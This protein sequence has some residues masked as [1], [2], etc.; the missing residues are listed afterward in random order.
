MNLFKYLHYYIYT[1]KMKTE[2]LKSLNQLT[3]TFE[4]GFILIVYIISYP[5]TNSD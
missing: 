2:V 5:L 1:N 3:L 4:L